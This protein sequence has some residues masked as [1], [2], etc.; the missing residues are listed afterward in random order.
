MLFSH[1]NVDVEKSAIVHADIHS[2]NCTIDT[3]MFFLGLSFKILILCTV[4]LHGNEILF[5]AD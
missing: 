4:F 1:L 3:V 5:Y 2:S